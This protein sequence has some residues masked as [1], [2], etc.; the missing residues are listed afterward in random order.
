[1]KISV[2][3]KTLA[4]IL[5]IG[6][7]SISNLSSQVTANNQPLNANRSKNTTTKRTILYDPDVLRISGNSLPIGI[8]TVLKNGDT[9]KTKM[10]LNGNDKWTKYKLEV[11][12][13]SYSNGKIKIGKTTDYKKF[14]SI[15]VNVYTRKWFL[16]GK[17]K[18]LFTQK[19]PYNYETS[20][21]FLTNG[22]QIKAPGN[23]IQFGIRTWFDNKMFVDKWATRSGKNL[24]NFILVPDGGHISNS[25][26]DFKINN[27]P[28]KIINDKVKLIVRLS[29][30]PAITDTLQVMLDYIAHYDCTIIN[31]DLNVNVN[32]FMDSIIN[33]KIMKIDVVGVNS[34]KTFNYLVNVN[35]GSITIGSYGSEGMAGLAGSDGLDGLNGSD[36][37]TSVKTETDSN[38]NITTTIITGPAGNGGN[39][40]NGLDGRNGESGSNAGNITIN[41]KPSAT[42]YLNIIKAISRGG[43]GGKGGSGGRGG[44][45]GMGGNGNPSGSAGSNGIDGRS[46][47]EGSNGRDGKVNFILVQV[48]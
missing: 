9:L 40:S 33:Q 28:Y 31:D 20:I 2:K 27:D 16:G 32:V 42:P 13:G 48:Q 1:M 12:S 47:L 6:M 26:G 25:K 17:D 7:I 38:G 11:D 22:K 34:H 4:L 10:F 45:G 5:I 43:S 21:G 30:C 46:G 41:Y 3:F 37:I 18:W 8:L 29:K 44:R 14:D 39:G 19:I 36:G 23:H 24:N 15:T 35:G